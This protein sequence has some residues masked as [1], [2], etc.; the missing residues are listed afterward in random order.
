M[1]IANLHSLFNKPWYI[2]ESYAQA[3]LPL[4]L[5]ILSGKEVEKSKDVI[6]GYVAASGQAI[7]EPTA[8]SVAVLSIKT[9]I[10]KYD[11]FCGP[12]GTKS[13]MRMLDSFKN[14]SSI[15][16]VVLDIDSGGGQVY[17][18]PE[19]HDYI[20][21]Y[22]KPIVTYT[23][24][25]LC[26]AA[27]YIAAGSSYIIANKRA[28][29]I[30]SIGAYSQILDI[31]GFYKKQGATLHTIY[32]TKSTQKNEGYRKVLEGDYK[33]Y[34]KEELDPLVDTFIVD[35]QESLT[36]LNE[37]VFAGATYKPPKALELG[38]INEI[39]TMQDAINKVI[40]LSKINKS[41]KT[42]KK[43]DRNFPKVQAVLGMETDF[44]SNDQGVYLSE[45]QLTTLETSLENHATELANQQTEHET[46]VTAA[47]DPLI[48][49]I[50][51]LTNGSNEVTSAIDAALAAADIP[52]N[53]LTDAEAVASLSAL[54]TEYGKKDGAKPTVVRDNADAS[55]LGNDNLV[56]G[57]DISKAMNN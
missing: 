49:Q 41:S 5:N 25:Y 51:A 4:L 31:T 15:A 1:S 45:E 48:A 13:M 6:L 33:T 16:G 40:E 56:G 18:T 57:Y 30:G 55:D 7:T 29:A 24:G 46:A 23:D 20:T 53:Q 44:E 28:D 9:P 42:T 14:D 54:L 19:F 32:A 11:Q 47:T 2:E 26:S 22:P 39:G 8:G 27:Y 38:L 12:I 43:M 34:I 3:H 17:G 52:R 37:K 21:S 35:M 10:L 36:Q 50:T